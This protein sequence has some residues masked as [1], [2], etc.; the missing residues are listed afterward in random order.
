MLA[1]TANLARFGP[2]FPLTI[3]PVLEALEEHVVL[4]KLLGTLGSEAG[5][6]LGHDAVAVRIGHENPHP[7][8][9][10]PRWSPP[11]TAPGAELVA[12]LGRARPDPHGLPHGDGHG[13]C[14]GPLRLADPRG[15]L[16]SDFVVRQGYSLNDYYRTSASPENASEEDIKRA[17]RRL[18]RKLPPRRQPG[19]EAEEQFKKVSQ[20]YDVLSDPEKKRAFDMGADPYAMAGDARLRAGLLVQRRHGRL[21]RRPGRRGR[22]SRSPSASAARPGRPGPARH[23]PLRGGVR[24]RGGADPRHGRRVRDLRGC[25]GAAGHRHVAPATSATGAARSSR[26]SAR[27]LGQVMTTPAVHDAARATAPIIPTPASSAP[28]EG[29]VRTRRTLKLKVPAG[30]DT[31]TRI[32]LTGEGEVGPGAGPAGD[33]YVEVRGQPPRDLTRAAATT[34]TASVELPMTA[35]ALGTTLQLWTFDGARD[36]DVGARDPAGRDVDHARA[37][38]HPPARQRPR[39]PHRPHRDRDADA[40]HARAGGPAAAAATLRGE[41][42]PEGKLAPLEKGLLGKLKDAS[43]L[44]DPISAAGAWSDEPMTDRMFLVG[45]PRWLAASAG[46]EVE[47]SGAE[48]RHAVTVVEV[49]AWVRPSC[50]RRRGP[51]RERRGRTQTGSRGVHGP[52]GLTSTD[53]PEPEPRFVLVQ[54]LAKGGRDEQAV[55]TATELRRRRGRAVAGGARRRRVARPGARGARTAPVGAVCSSRP[56]SSPGAPGCRWSPPRPAPPDVAARVSDAA[57]AVVLHEAAA[58]A[59]LRVE[60]PTMGDVVVVVGPEGGITDGRARRPGGRGWPPGPARPRGAALL[61]RRTGRARGPRRGRP[62]AVMLSRLRTGRC[63][64]RRCCRP[65]C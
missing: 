32:Q 46:D 63:S 51:A 38:R 61:D 22:G 12:G 15:A 58:D 55:E 49:R 45:R 28:G 35:A 26:C 60:V 33:L 41:E 16:R 57:L 21:L 24:L 34:C 62:V 27:F 5:T 19:P 8:S 18:A 52:A 42:R 3:G 59:A 43:R 39:R 50:S 23:R 56:R 64:G 31:G 44:A 14:R 2:D 17:Y 36:L 4:L 29:R 53:E 13:A 1:G 9:P 30:V 7:G 48:G 65:S 11:G 6:G 47:V 20:A 40:P 10:R 54:A 37:R 25:R